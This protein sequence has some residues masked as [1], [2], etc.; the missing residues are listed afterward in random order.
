M[1]EQNIKK[2]GLV[3]AGLGLEAVV[4]VVGAVILGPQIDQALGWQ[5]G[6]TV[7][8]LIVS[9]LAWFVHLFRL[10]GQFMPSKGKTPK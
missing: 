3:F 8:L 7:G 2:R 1:D 4:L 9:L 6:A 5:G 10:I